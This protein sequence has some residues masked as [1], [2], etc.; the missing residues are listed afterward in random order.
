MDKP[1]SQITRNEWIAF[2]WRDATQMGDAERM[3]EMGFA[4]TPDEAMQAMEEWDL[5]AEERA[6]PEPEEEKG[7]IQ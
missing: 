5:T 1:L 7:V 2:Q 6:E 3:M 4:R